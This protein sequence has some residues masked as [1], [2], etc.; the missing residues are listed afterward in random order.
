MSKYYIRPN[1]VEKSQ[2]KIEMIHH[3]KGTVVESLNQVVKAIEDST[4]TLHKLSVCMMRGLA[5]TICQVLQNLYTFELQDI[6]DRLQ[7]DLLQILHFLQGNS[8]LR[9]LSIFGYVVNN[10]I[11]TKALC[12]MI[13]HNETI[14]TLTIHPNI[15]Y[16][17]YKT[18]ARALLQNTTLQNLYVFYEVDSLKEAIRQLKVDENVPVHPNWNLEIDSKKRNH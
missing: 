5:K 9:E 8:T 11:I 1:K 6:N 3:P 10:R 7:E 14:H 13:E 16:R 4:L 17:N 18:V 15:I 2:V 12:E